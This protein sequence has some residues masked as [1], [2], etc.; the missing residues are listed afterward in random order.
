M[1][2]VSDDFVTRL[3]QRA[4]EAEDL[5]R[6]PDATIADF[7]AEGMGRLLLPA[8]YGGEQA[9]FSAMLSPSCTSSR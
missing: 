1:L 3:A 5:R 7:R 2:T 4:A 8:R 6:L 9:P